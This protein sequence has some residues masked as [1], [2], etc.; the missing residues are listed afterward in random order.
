M[1]RQFEE[2]QYSYGHYEW[3]AGLQRYQTLRRT[4]RGKVESGAGEQEMETPAHYRQNPHGLRKL[5]G[6]CAYVKYRKKGGG[7][8]I[9][10]LRT[11]LNGCGYAAHFR[12]GL[13]AS[14]RVVMRPP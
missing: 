2:F 6:L 4:L 9:A 14:L 11:S 3:S 10:D 7:E 5:S 12:S 1:F 8:E 13:V